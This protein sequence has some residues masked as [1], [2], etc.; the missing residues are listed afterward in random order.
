MALDLRG[1]GDISAEDLDWRVASQAPYVS[2]PLVYRGRLYLSSESGRVMVCDPATGEVTWTGRPG[3]AFWSSPV[4]G[5]GKIYL[6]DEPGETVVLTAGPEPEVLSRNPL[7]E[8]ARGS[9]A[10][11]GPRLLIRT[12]SHLVCVEGPREN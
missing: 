5:D 10:I 9:I 6:L 4:A 7:G 3:T 12:A 8:P 11:A 1:R 2:S